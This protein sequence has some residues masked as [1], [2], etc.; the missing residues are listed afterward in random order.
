MRDTS[1]GALRAFR[2]I[3]EHGTFTRAAAVLGVTPS[4]LS[5]ALRQLEERLGARLLQ[6]TTRRV[7]LTDAGRELLARVTPALGAIDA[8]LDDMRQ[9]GGDP[10]G[11]L[12]LTM[13]QIVVR[14]LLT[15]I[16]EE[17]LAAY[18]RITLD[19]RIEN[20]LAD[21]VGEGLDA[22][23]R[24]G[25]LLERDMIAVPLGGKLRSVVIGAP[26][27]FKRHGR[28]QH[29]R[30][31]ARHNCVSFRFDSGAL[32]RWEFARAGRWF[33]IAVGGNLVVNDAELALEAAK[34]GIALYY[35]VEPLVRTA[36]AEGRLET[37]L[38]AFLPPFEGFYLYYP[39]RLQMPPKLRVFI[40]FLRTRVAA[41]SGAKARLTP[42]P[43]T[44]AAEHR[45]RTAPLL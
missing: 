29:P 42:R 20:R 23:I 14:S 5:Q 17:F 16:L 6:R 26:A 35:A 18:P 32:Y 2:L 9:R 4:A 3:A 11:T 21:L 22:G 7:G 38:D 40:D 25:E 27:Y 30:D 8:A 12:R 1:A 15:P 13:P 44:T 24:L 36:L 33:E 39:S 28:P 45:A 19:L 43:R 37:A 34:Q 41:L 31:L 10:A